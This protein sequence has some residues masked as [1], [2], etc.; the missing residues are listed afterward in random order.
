MR[1]RTV[2]RPT[3][4]TGPHGETLAASC[5]PSRR[6][7]RRR[8]SATRERHPAR[9]GGGLLGSGF[10]GRCRRR[11]WW[12]SSL[13]SSWTEVRAKKRQLGG[14]RVLVGVEEGR[15][16]AAGKHHHFAVGGASG[17]L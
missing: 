4:R 14:Q 8:A 17:H 13:S 9:V 2:R 1:A 11:R 5:W 10:G 15:V 6:R 3:S 7:V 16:V 12:R